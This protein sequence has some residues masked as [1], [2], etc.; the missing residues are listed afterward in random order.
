M[1]KIVGPGLLAG[2]LMLIVGMVL[3]IAIEKMIPGIMAEYKTPGLFRPWT[4]PLMQIYFAYPFILG[5]ALAYAWDKIKGC[6]GENKV[7]AFVWGLFLVAT[8]PGMFITYS[9]FQV[10][11]AMVLSWTI[12]GIVNVLVA[13]LVFAKMNS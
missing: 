12:C 6:L 7:W 1:R 9:S 13:G 11:L 10:S 3:N 4:D 2:L 8:L 5:L